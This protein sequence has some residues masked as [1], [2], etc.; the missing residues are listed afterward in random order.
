MLSNIELKDVIGMAFHGN[1]D[2]NNNEKNK[3]N[4]N[5]NNCKAVVCKVPYN[6]DTTKYNKNDYQTFSLSKK[7]K[8][9][10]FHQFTN[11]NREGSSGRMVIVDKKKRKLNETFNEGRNVKKKKKRYHN[12]YS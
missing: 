4:N 6:Y 7:V 10:I 5:N 2:G 3:N 8:L 11:G 1:D 9:L 12:S